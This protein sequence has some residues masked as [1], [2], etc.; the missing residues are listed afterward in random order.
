MPQLV[1]YL[2]PYS[3]DYNLIKGVAYRVQGLLRGADAHP[4]RPNRGDWTALGRITAVIPEGSS[5]TALAV[6]WVGARTS[7]LVRFASF[8][9]WLTVGHSGACKTL[10]LS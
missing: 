3:P 10:A 5:T 1:L 8:F 7:A 9:V 4:R 2:T 6:R